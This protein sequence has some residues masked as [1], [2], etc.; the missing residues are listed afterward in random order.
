MKRHVLPAEPFTRVTVYADV[1]DWPAWRV[2]VVG[3]RLIVDVPDCANDIPA[4]AND[5]RTTAIIGNLANVI[6][7][8]SIPLLFGCELLIIFLL[9]MEWERCAV[10]DRGWATAHL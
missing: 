1:P 4:R 9:A 5:R 7:T 8:I 6:L 3:F 10:Y 2:I